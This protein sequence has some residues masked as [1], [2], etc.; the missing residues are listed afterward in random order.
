LK[1]ALSDLWLL[2]DFQALKVRASK[3]AIRWPDVPFR[4]A[5]VNSFGYG[6]SNAHVVLDEAEGF[7]RRSTKTHVSSYFSDTEDFFAEEISTR[8]LTLVFS[9][10]DEDSLRA[11][12]K[13]ISKHLV[14][15]GVNVKLQDLSYTLSERRTRHFHRAYLVTE[16]T[17]LDEGAFV[18]GKKSNDVPR[19]GFVFTGQGAQWS[20]MGESVINS[21]PAAKSL[22]KHLD[23]VLQNLSTPPSWSLLSK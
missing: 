14:N 13:A 23:N 18:F 17:T 5:S 8:P 15:P 11:Y 7:L 19:I 3:T 2:V 22:L 10:N 4:R 9:A 6:G 20:Q 16:S 12:C 21:F 1:F